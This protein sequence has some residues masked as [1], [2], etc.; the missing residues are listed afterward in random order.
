MCDATLGENLMV[1]FFF[2]YFVFFK[3]N[4]C[5]YEKEPLDSSLMYRHHCNAFITIIRTFAGNYFTF[6]L[7]CINPDSFEMLFTPIS[8]CHVI[9]HGGVCF[10]FLN[11]I[12]KSLENCFGT[13]ILT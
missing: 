4:S 8:C 2:N 13:Q 9:F 10:H 6:L 12:R 3:T 11:E 5:E 7:N 1:S